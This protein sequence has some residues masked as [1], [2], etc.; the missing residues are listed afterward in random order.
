MPTEARDLKS[1]VTETENNKNN[2]KTVA[3]QIDNKLVELGGERATD[4]SDVAN[5][6]GNMVG[7]YLQY[8]SINVNIPIPKNVQ[9]PQVKE[10]TVVFSSEITKNLNFDSK[11][12]KLFVNARIYTNYGDYPNYDKTV[13]MILTTENSL[14]VRFPYHPNEWLEVYIRIKKISNKKSLFEIAGNY[15][16]PAGEYN[17]N[18]KFTVNLSISTGFLECYSKN[19][20]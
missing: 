3:T 4:L 2:L 15:Y 10:E 9:I 19:I 6:M 7:Q 1:T 13:A 17:P 12:E 5:K 18:Y 16:D 14:L 11:I 8:A 20:R